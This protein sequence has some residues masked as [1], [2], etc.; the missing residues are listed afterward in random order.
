V[1]YLNF[2][3]DLGQYAAT[4]RYIRQNRATLLIAFYEITGTTE[5]EMRQRAWQYEFGHRG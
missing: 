4:N 2:R 5:R 1:N 3:S